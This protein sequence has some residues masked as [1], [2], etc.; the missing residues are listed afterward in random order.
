[1]HSKGNNIREIP[2][3]SLKDLAKAIARNTSMPANVF[4]QVLQDASVKTVLA[5]PRVINIIKGEDWRAPIM[6]YICYYYEPDSKN[7]QTRMQQR[8]KDYQIFDNEL[9]MTSV[10]GPLLRCINKTEGQEILQEVHAR[11]CG[12]HISARTLASKVLQQ[13]FY[14]PAMIDDIAKL[15]TTCEACQKFSHRCK[16][17]AQS[18]QLIAPSWLLQR[19]GIDVVGKLTPAQGNYTFTIIAV[20]CF[21]KWVEAKPVTNIISATIQKF[22]W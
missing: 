16:A 14:W 4:F 10:S 2:S 7:E 17:P 13:G 9:Y 15:V 5:E 8:A 1:M 19:W 3:S 20:E 18:S 22:L 12:G 6:A 21:T 11:I